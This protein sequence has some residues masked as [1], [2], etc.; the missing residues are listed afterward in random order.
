V[1]QVVVED[2]AIMADHQLV[3]L[4]QVDLVLVL[5]EQHIPL[6][7]QEEMQDMPQD[8]AVVVLVETVVDMVDQV[9]LVS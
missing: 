2:Q 1:E 6:F 5:M 9:V 4:E 8:Q 7:L 3:P